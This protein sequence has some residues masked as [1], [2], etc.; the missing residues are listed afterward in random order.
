MANLNKILIE[1]AQAVSEKVLNALS[2]IKELEEEIQTIS[3]AKGEQ[4]PPGPS[5]PP[6][7]QGS[8]GIQ[9]P[10]GPS[11]SDGR[12]GYTFTPSLSSSGLL[13]WINDGNL[14]N[15]SAIN[16]KGPKGDIGP[17]GPTGPQGKQGPIGPRGP[18]GYEGEISNSYNGNRRNVPIS[19]YA[20]GELY[21]YVYGSL[22]A[23]P[24][25]V[26]AGN[27]NSGDITL[28]KNVLGK[29]V[30]VLMQHGQSHTLTDNNLVEVVSFNAFNIENKNSG[31]ISFI[32]VIWYH[33]YADVRQ[34]RF[35]ISVSGTTMR[36]SSTGGRYLKEVYII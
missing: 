15:P 17:Q 20:V 4:G 5:G 25:R 11:G 29:T 2:K 8:P 10:P 3:R 13:S 14:P 22:Q 9:G 16:I 28:S 34:L 21:N 12:N 30:I 6:G 33:S 18:A 19:E 7:V 24:E 27:V 32:S 1:F 26:W 23:Q 36:V 31:D 35:D